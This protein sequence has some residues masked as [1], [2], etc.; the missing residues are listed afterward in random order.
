MISAVP[1]SGGF[2]AVGGPPANTSIRGAQDDEASVDETAVV[3]SE[4]QPLESEGTEGEQRG[5]IRNLLS[6][7]FRGV[8]DVRLR[9]NFA[10]ELQAIELRSATA[11]ASESGASFTEGAT[12]SV[13][14]FAEGATLTEEQAT[15]FGDAAATFEAALTEATEAGLSPQPL[16][17]ET[18]AA[19]DAFAGALH[20]IFAAEEPVAPV[21][22]IETDGVDGTEESTDSDYAALLD[23]LDALYAA[24]FETATAEVSYAS[25]APLSEPSGNGVAYARFLA[26]YQA[27]FEATTE[28]VST[29]VTTETDSG[30]ELDAP[31]E[32]RLDVAA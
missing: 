1:G 3:E 7:H 31:T 14:T 19:L 27:I 4:D 28:P 30:T 23:E 24:T 10:E 5:V 16:A 32:P 12:T 20:E 25:P 15:A 2:H 8:A 21:E 18:R 6:G 11:A 9:I 17:E 13:T 22:P 29:E 26:E